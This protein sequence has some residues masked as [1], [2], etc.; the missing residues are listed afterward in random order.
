MIIR[1][2]KSFFVECFKHCSKSAFVLLQKQLRTGYGHN[3]Q[4]QLNNGINE[5]STAWSQAHLPKINQLHLIEENLS[6]IAEHF[7]KWGAI[8]KQVL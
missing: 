4:T 7:N 3:F 6:K 1:S 8:C 2:K 5:L